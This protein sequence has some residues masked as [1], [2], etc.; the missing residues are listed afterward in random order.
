MTD[1]E[2]RE[3]VL[4]KLSDL[5]GTI[6]NLYGQLE[7]LEKTITLSIQNTEARFEGALNVIQKDVDGFGSRLDSKISGVCENVDRLR[8]DVADIY[9]KDRKLEEKISKNSERI[10]S[11]E[12]SNATMRWLLG[13]LISV[14]VLYVTYRG[15]VDL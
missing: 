2:F 15:V 6:Q 4:N 8:N 12:S 1:Q 7:S 14:L 9:E 5:T 13:F 10:K 11:L 3:S